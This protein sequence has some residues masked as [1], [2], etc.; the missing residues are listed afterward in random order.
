MAKKK[1]KKKKKPVERVNYFAYGSNLSIAQMKERCP[2]SKFVRKG[3]LKGVRLEFRNFS[4]RWGGHVADITGDKD[5]N[6]L[7]YG[8]IYSLPV[9]DLKRLDV[10][11]GYPL[12][13]NRKLVKIHGNNQ[14]DIGWVYYIQRK[15][16]MGLPS[17][18]YLGIIKT[19]AHNFDFPKY[20]REFLGK[21][22]VA[23]KYTPP[24]NHY[25][26]LLMSKNTKDATPIWKRKKPNGTP[27]NMNGVRRNLQRGCVQMNLPKSED[28]SIVRLPVDNDRT[29]IIQDDTLWEDWEDGRDFDYHE[30]RDLYNL[31][32]ENEDL[33][34]EELDIH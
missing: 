19:G 8:I 31:H 2:D 33:D 24:S 14:C 20:W 1:N 25:S 18:K 17:K 22:K 32:R 4:S 5:K 28:S 3:F 26:H 29:H 7:V 27:V 11:E 30:R 12:V 13:Y 21:M 10:Y 23:P 9:A 6:K 34:F 16:K 15:T